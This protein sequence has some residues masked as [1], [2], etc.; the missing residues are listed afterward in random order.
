MT[1]TLTFTFQ[2]LISGNWN[3]YLL[4]AVVVLFLGYSFLIA[5]TVV[6][7]DGSKSLATQVQAAQ[8]NVS[9]L[10]INYFNLA[11]NIDMTKATQLG[12]VDSKTPDF[13]Y[14]HPTAETV[15]MAR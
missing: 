5:K 1:N 15:A 4:I 13:A 12:L 8:G 14:T 6:A 9:N 2:N 3:K 10:E 7:I 11:S